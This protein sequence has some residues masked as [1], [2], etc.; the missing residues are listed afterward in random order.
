MDSNK[1]L[2]KEDITIPTKEN[3]NIFQDPIIVVSHI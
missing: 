2:T 3:K 1:T